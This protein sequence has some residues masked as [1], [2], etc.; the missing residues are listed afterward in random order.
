MKR[1]VCVCLCFLLLLSGCS[2]D[3]PTFS[4]DIYGTPENFDPLFASS[5][6][7]LLIVDNTMIGLLSFDKAGQIACAGAESYSM[8]SDGRTYTF[9][10]RPDAT[11]SNDAPVTAHDYVYAF[12]R[13]FSS[14]HPS[15]YA[16]SFYCITGAKNRVAGS[17]AAI[18][19]VAESDTTLVFTLTGPTDQFLELLCS[20]AA[21]PCNEEFFTSTNGRYGLEKN[22]CLFNGPFIISNIYD[23]KIYLA[24]NASFY[25][26]NTV[27]LPYV[28]LTIVD[29]EEVVPLDRFT[30]KNTDALF[31]TAQQ[32]STLGTN[33]GSVLSSENCTW[34]L[35]FSDSGNVSD[36]LLRNALAFTTDVES[37]IEGD[38]EWIAPAKGLVPT[39]ITMSSG[40]YR[41][42]VGSVLPDLDPTTAKSHLKQYLSKV[43]LEKLPTITILCPDN[44]KVRQALSE[45]LQIWQRDLQVYLSVSVVS[46]S[47]IDAALLSGNYDIVLTPISSTYNDPM[48]VLSLFE[49]S[50]S[51]YNN[52]HYDS[53]LAQASS[54]I[55]SS[56]KLELY[57]Q[58]ELQLKKDIPCL[59]LFS[60]RN[61]LIYNRSYTGLFTSPSFSRVFFRHVQAS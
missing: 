31:L 18:G 33:S 27:S 21:V 6:E 61:Y 47:E 34:T 46:Q 48:S 30:S 54:V 49:S 52:A 57:R 36:L 35:V 50:N 26:S 23:N 7:E 4:F 17:S 39:S 59:P 55:S 3:T 2:S 53:L 11:W 29:E 41:D 60:E 32:L 28:S 38:M 20:S 42:Q 8:S 1:L 25:G 56:E 37:F 12:N 15:P 44:E 16:S 9:Q 51:I 43:G 24:K 40:T 14:S 13:M 58:A 5:S 10:L 45:Q 22:T 19:V